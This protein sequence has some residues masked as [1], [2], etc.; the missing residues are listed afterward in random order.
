MAAA[1]CTHHATPSSSVGRHGVTPTTGNHWRAGG[2][3]LGIRGPRVD[4]WYASGAGLPTS[5]E[6][7]GGWGL[8]DRDPGLLHPPDEPDQQAASIAEEG[9][10]VALEPVT[11]ELETPADGEQ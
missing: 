10:R 4:R 6:T 9:G 5:L 8:G 2:A 3:L 1:L 11:E 7:A